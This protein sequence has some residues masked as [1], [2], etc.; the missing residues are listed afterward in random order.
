MY[1]MCQFDSKYF[2]CMSYSK[3][4]TNSMKSSTSKATDTQATPKDTEW[5]VS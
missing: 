1:I 3:L 4:I 5:P 2:T